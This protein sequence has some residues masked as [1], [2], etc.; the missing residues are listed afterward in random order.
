M[1]QKVLRFLES[2]V[3]WIALG[4]AVIFLGWA[5][6]YYLISNPISQKLEGQ[7][8]DPGSVDQF[9]A[10]HAAKRLQDKMADVQVPSFNVEDFTLALDQKLALDG[11]KPMELASGDFDYS[12][13]DIG[14]LPGAI[15]KLGVPVQVLPTLPAAQPL[16]VAAALDT[17][18]PANAAAQS[19]GAATGGKDTRLVVAAF[20]I[21]WSDIFD[22]WN[23]SFGPPQPGAQPRLTPADFQILG[24]TAYRDEKIGNNWGKSTEVQPFDS[25]LPPYPPAGNV[26]RE[27][28]Y[29]Q[30]VAKLSNALVAPVLPTPVAGVV[31]KDPLAYL[32]TASEQPGNAAET[33]QNGTSRA[34][35]L[36]RPT[37]ANM[38]DSL[39]GTLLAQY[40]G[41]PPGGFGGGRFGGGPPRPAAP[42]AEQQ[43]ATPAP[44]APIPPA[45]GT[46][47]PVVVLAHPNVVPNPIP[48]ELAKV[49]V[50]P[51]VAKNPDLCVYIIDDSVEAGKTYRYRIVYKALNPLFHKAPQHAAKPQ[52]VNQF[53]L[54]SPMSDFSPEITVPV[55][56]YFYCGKQQG[57]MKAAAFPFDVFTWSDGKWQQK[58]FNANIGDPIGAADGGVNYSTGYSFVDKHL[59][60]RT[61]KT[62]VTLVDSDGIAEVRDATKDFES[63]EYKQK[64]QWVEQDKNGGT[65][66]IVQPGAPPG[67]YGGPPG[68]QPGYGGPPGYRG[69]PGYGGPPS[70]GGP[71]YG[72]TR[73]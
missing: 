17:L 67:G 31:W 48:T 14:N 10:D 46:V 28:S 35:S 49:N 36:G 16:L 51:N 5:T 61:S 8:V 64:S 1:M 29:L 69:P 39:D 62:M 45:P 71:G 57:V 43:P 32:P 65:Q 52:W 15:S 3:E 42:P 70:Y 40:R 53:D 4:I 44:P 66:N 13:F 38:S 56:T 21:P 47:D 68:G 27:E 30:A 25:S 34:P 37:F 19:S 58:T 2:S 9:I 73:Q 54:V 11:T 72:G 50:A 60:P 41:G 22:Q 20:T 55:Q 63:P 24:I 26:A 23:K 6:Y 33:G 7:S 12:P 18:A 59:I